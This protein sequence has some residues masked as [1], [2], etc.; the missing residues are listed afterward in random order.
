MKGRRLRIV[1]R[2]WGL[3]M[4]FTAYPPPEVT[5]GRYTYA[6]DE[7]TFQVYRP[8]ARIEVGSFCS[9]AP[10]ARILA[11]SQHARARAATFP[12]HGVLFDPAGG[13]RDSPFRPL[14]L[15]L[16]PPRGRIEDHVKKG[17]TIIGND[18]WIGLGSTIL[19][20]VLVGDGAVIAAG[21]VVSK[22]VPPYAIV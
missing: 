12:L 2:A 7:E 8:D 20:G 21:A 13:R 10:G 14:K 18:V 6:D 3:R 5:T 1:N 16:N 9:I 19:E 22:A 15:L 17:D 11:G 4:L